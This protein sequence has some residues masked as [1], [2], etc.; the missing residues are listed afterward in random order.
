[1]PVMVGVW[2]ETVGSDVCFREHDQKKNPNS[3]EAKFITNKIQ[4]TVKLV[5][6]MNIAVA[7]AN[8]QL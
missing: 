4:A 8:N 6:I 3:S 2:P 1:M 5:C 7:L